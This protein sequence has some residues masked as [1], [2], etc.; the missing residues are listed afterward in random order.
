MHCEKNQAYTA[1]SS[2]YFSLMMSVGQCVI[3]TAGE[4]KSFVYEH[5]PEKLQC[6]CFLSL[7]DIVPL[8]KDPRTFLDNRL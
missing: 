6:Y 8:P 1:L 2:I 4:A 3:G 7:A 5:F